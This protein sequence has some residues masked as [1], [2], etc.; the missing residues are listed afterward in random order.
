MTA[1]LRLFCRFETKLFLVVIITQ[2]KNR[3]KNR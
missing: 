2:R 1:L 3:G